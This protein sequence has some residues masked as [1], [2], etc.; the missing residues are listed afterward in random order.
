MNR[1]ELVKLA[2]LFPGS[3]ISLAAEEQGVV[4]FANSFAESYRVWV[5]LKQQELANPGTVNMGAI[6]AWEEVKK[7]FR[8]LDLILRNN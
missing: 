7:R 4:Y 8:E 2:L 5:T 1:R 6:K 3:L